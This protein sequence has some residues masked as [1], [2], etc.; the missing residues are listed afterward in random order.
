MQGD[1][2]FIVCVG[3]T[4]RSLDADAL[5]ISNRAVNKILP[6]FTLFALLRCLVVKLRKGSGKD[7]HSLYLNFKILH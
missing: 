7:S 2:A 5:S 6:T 1:I 3:K 4:Y